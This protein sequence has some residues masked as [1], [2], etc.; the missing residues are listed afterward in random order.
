MRSWRTSNTITSSPESLAPTLML[1]VVPTCVSPL[2]RDA[3]W[4]GLVARRAL[5]PEVVKTVGSAVK[6]SLYSYEPLAPAE[7]CQIQ[8]LGL[9]AG[10][11]PP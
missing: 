11:L 8:L 10:H 9:L 2:S 3:R 6:A 1:G 4:S 7:R 5:E